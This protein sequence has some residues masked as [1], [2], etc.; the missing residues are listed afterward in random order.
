MNFAAIIAGVFAV[1]KAIPAIRDIVTQVNAR[2]T[3]WELSKITSDYSD[4]HEK[5]DALVI[6]ISKA[7]T[8]EQRRI[9]A[10]MLA[11]Y[12]SGKF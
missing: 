2:I 4:R 3:Q 7:T 9:Y 11:D 10:S 5:V 12:T 8:R 1:A 6:S